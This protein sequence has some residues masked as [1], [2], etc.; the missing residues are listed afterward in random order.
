MKTGRV[1]AADARAARWSPP[2]C[3]TVMGSRRVAAQP[4]QDAVA[5]VVA[6]AHDRVGRGEEPEVLADPGRGARLEPVVR[7][8]AHRQGV[9]ADHRGGHATGR[10]ARSAPARVGRYDT[11]GQQPGVVDGQQVAG[12]STRIGSRATSAS[13]TRKRRSEPGSRG[14]KGMRQQ[15]CRLR[16]GEQ[17]ELRRR[18]AP[19]SRPATSSPA[20]PARGTAAR[21]GCP[22]RRGR[23]RTA[24]CR[25]RRASG[26]RPAADA[27]GLGEQLQQRAPRT[28]PATC[29]RGTSR[30]S[31]SRSS[32]GDRVREPVLERLGDHDRADV[33]GQAV[34]VGGRVDVD[35]Q[36]GARPPPACRRRPG[37]SAGR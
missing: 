25:C 3:A 26:P 23:G 18:S 30:R 1:G 8:L 28:G 35:A 27:S 4:A 34:D 36:A 9:V 37:R 29:A 13:R 15:L 21:A 19:R 32:C 11:S 16:G 2:G 7:R 14:V 33:V 10:R 5:G 20:T 6:D 24:R 22:S 31:V 17:P 12:A